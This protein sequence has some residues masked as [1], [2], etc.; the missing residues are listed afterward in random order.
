MFFTA[1]IKFGANAIATRINSRQDQALN[2]FGG[3]IIT[4]AY[5]DSINS[6]EDLKGKTFM[7]VEKSSFGG[8]QMAYKTIKDAGLDPFQ[9]F[10]KM[11]FGGKHDNV[12]FAIQNEAVQAGTVRTDTLERMAASG[13]ITMEDFKI[14]NKQNYANFPFICSTALHPEWPL[15]KTSATSDALTQKVVAAL[16]QI[17]KDN[18]A[19][20]KAKIIGWSEPLDYSPVEELQKALTVGAFAK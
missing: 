9:D 7:A 8:W 15:T 5:N 17:T 3:V 12:V 14:I 1:K 11:E 20:A 13:T 10:A 19:A 2:S 6:L 18:P 4:S 16:K